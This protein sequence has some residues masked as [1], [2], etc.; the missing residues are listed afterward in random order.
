MDEEA[1]NMSVRQFLKQLGITAQREIE[2][3]VR[4]RVDAGEVDTA[5]TLP[6]R[7]TISVEGLPDGIVVTGEIRLA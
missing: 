5:A 1:F 6:A 3:G 2:F 7:A 4:E